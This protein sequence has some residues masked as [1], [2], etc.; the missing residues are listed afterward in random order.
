M[1]SATKMNQSKDISDRF[2]HYFESRYPGAQVMD[3]R[4]LTSGYESDVF[5]FINQPAK[6]DPKPLILR[7]FPGEN[8]TTK[9]VQEVR[10]LHLL[11]QAGFPVAAVLGYET[12]P[13]ILGKPF[14]IMEKLEGKAI[15]PLLYQY[16]RAQA[17]IL[18]DRFSALLVRL[19]QL[20][21]RPFTPQP[22]RYEANPALL[23]DE[24]LADSRQWFQR[25]GI[26]GFEQI[27]D[28]LEAHKSE[29]TMQLA[30]IHLD[31]HANNVFLCDDDRLAVIDWTQIGVGDYRVDL[32]WTL[33]IMGDYGQPHWR[34]RI[35]QIYC[36]E[37]RHPIE[38]L[39]YFM[40]IADTRN[41]ASTII[42]SQ[43]NLAVLGLNP[44]KSGSLEQQVSSIR[45]MYWR[46]QQTTG[47]AIPEVEAVL[48]VS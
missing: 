30:V 31:F 34:E 11:Q 44:V 16:P 22:D 48:K 24:D 29:I 42:S 32:C 17:D 7:V 47:V 9:Q 1:H 40:V 37:A 45:K 25:F 33:L 20:D 10:G 3:F 19:H 13:A 8:V 2:Q 6:G 4:F 18:L 27:T 23:L 28:W 38:G 39:D 21:W 46:I 43:T 35:L 36:Q 14:T 41:L 26:P 12:D 15:W 5:T